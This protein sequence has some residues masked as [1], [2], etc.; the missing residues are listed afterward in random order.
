MGFAVFQWTVLMESF[1]LLFTYI[2]IFCPYPQKYPV[3]LETP[4][5]SETQN[6]QLQN[7]IVS[8]VLNNGLHHI[9]TATCQSK[10]SGKCVQTKTQ[11]SLG[12]YPFLS[13]FAVRM[14]PC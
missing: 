1:L 5:S 9:C 7:I 10:A 11:I 14:E 6:L 12:S 3:F 4:K 8:D 2:C 13:D